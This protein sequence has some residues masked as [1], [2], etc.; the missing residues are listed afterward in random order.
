[1]AKRD[2]EGAERLLNQAA[3][4]FELAMRTCYDESIVL[5]QYAACMTSRAAVDMDGGSNG[6]P[7]RYLDKIR[8]NLRAFENKHNA[9]GI[10]SLL[11]AMPG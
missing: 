11:A 5:E 4:Y 1:M 7:K 6:D 8:G 3:H 2:S 9:K 10:A